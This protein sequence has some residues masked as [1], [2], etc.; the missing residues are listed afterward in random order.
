MIKIFLMPLILYI[1]FYYIRLRKNDY[2]FNYKIIDEER[3]LVLLN[4]IYYDQDKII[5]KD[6]MIIPESYAL[7]IINA[8]EECFNKNISIK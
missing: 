7:D 3:N 4:Y 1:V 8:F 2:Y 5:R 6:K